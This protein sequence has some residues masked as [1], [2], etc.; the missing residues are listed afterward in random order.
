MARAETGVAIADDATTPSNKGGRGFSHWFG[1]NDLVS[2]T[3]PTFYET[4]LT[5]S[6]Q[7]GFDAGETVTFRFAGESG[8]RQRDITVSVPPGT[9]TMS[10][11]LGA[12]NDPITG[13][14]RYGAFS[15]D[16]GGQAGLQGL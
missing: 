13:V 9:G 10:E 3:T 2:T 11:L 4:G 16:A 15:L 7:H 1:L 14:G 5:L 6:S 12:L 8:A